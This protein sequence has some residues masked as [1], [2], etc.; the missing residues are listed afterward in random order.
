MELPD[1]GKVIEKAEQVTSFKDVFHIEDLDRPFGNRVEQAEIQETRILTPLQYARVKLESGWSDEIIKNIGSMEEYQIYKSAEL[2]ER[3]I[4]G[5][6]CLV[7]KDLDLEQKDSFGRTNKERMEQG[8]APL[9]PDG[10][11]YELHHI[12]QKPDSPLAELTMQEHRGKGNDT[13]LH[14]KTKESEID[15]EAF[16]NERS[17]H[18]QDRVKETE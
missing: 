15:R 8:L 16:G 7:R 5:K 10:R 18:W 13:I 4:G 9:A 11:P 12:G 3:E 6:P 17:E 14:I 2:V 1:L